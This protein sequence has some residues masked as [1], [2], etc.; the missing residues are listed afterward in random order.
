MPDHIPHRDA[1]WVLCQ[2]IATPQPGDTVYP[3]AL[4]KRQH[5]LFE[6]LLGNVVAP[7]QLTNRDRSTTIMID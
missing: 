7:S 2:V 5:D 3:P 1:I 4:L 6:E